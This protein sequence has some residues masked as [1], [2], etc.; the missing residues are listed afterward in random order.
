MKIFSVQVPHKSL[1]C[2]KRI[3][4][5]IVLLFISL[6]IVLGFVGSIRLFALENPVQTSPTVRNPQEPTGRQEHIPSEQELEME[7]KQ[8]RD[9]K[10]AEYDKT[11]KMAEDLLKMAQDLKSSIDKAGENT[12][13][14]DAIRQ[15]DKI[16]AL[17][18]KIKSRVKTGN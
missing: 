4:G 14:L 16:E 6:V 17:A 18:K 10:K 3:A 5:T 8:L 9:R 11:K 2:I 7:R 15:A 13:P 1:S 12:L